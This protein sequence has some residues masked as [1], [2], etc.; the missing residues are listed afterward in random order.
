MKHHLLSAC[1]LL[2]AS[3]IAPAQAISPPHGDIARDA[4]GLEATA[5]GW[6]GVGPD[7]RVALDREAVRFQP[8][9]GRQ[10]ARTHGLELRL[11][12]V[13]RGKKLLEA[14]DA[15]QRRHDMAVHYHRSRD[16]TERWQLRPEGVELSYEFHRPPTGTGDLVVQ[17]AVETELQLSDG[18]PSGALFSSDHGGVRIGGVTGIDA[19]GREIAGE[20]RATERTLELVL[21]AAFVDHCAYP[22][23]LDPLIGTHSSITPSGEDHGVPEVAYD[24]TN[25]QYLVVWQQEF[26]ASDVAIR[27]RLINGNGTA[28]GGVLMIQDGSLVSQRPTV[29]NVNSSNRFLVAWQEGPSLLGP[30]DLIG[31]CVDAGTGAISARATLAG[32]AASE[33]S[34]VAAGEATAVDDEAMLVWQ[35][36]SGDIEYA[37]VTCAAGSGPP[38]A[39]VSASFLAAA[40]PIDLAISRSG[41]TSGIYLVAWTA[42]DGVW[43]GT[44]DRDGNIASNNRRIESLPATRLAV[45]GDGASFLVAWDEPEALSSAS[46]VLARKVIYRG[47]TFGLQIGPLVFPGVTLG[48]DERDPAVSYLGAKYALA[49]SQQT[50]GLLDYDLQVRLLDSTTCEPCSNSLTL[51]VANAFDGVPAIGSQWSASRDGSTAPRDGDQALLAFSSTGVTPPFAGGVRTQL[52]EALSGGAVVDLQDGCGNPGNNVFN[53]PFALG[54]QDFEFQLEDAGS[55]VSVAALILGWPDNLIDCGPCKRLRPAAGY[56]LAPVVGGNASIP[57]PLPCGLLPLVGV[58]IETQWWTIGS[59]ASPCSSF[60]TV[61]FSNRVQVTIDF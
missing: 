52:L 48:V 16:L 34:P 20:L 57:S 35:L 30:F 38:V 55:T 8:A 49:W 1:C 26:S 41:G 4:C 13:R 54:N 9:L 39:G 33:H 60:P 44:L 51:D 19:R 53:G 18:S 11:V 31:R 10:A 14:A 23:V 3:S 15:T 24:A 2:A 50:A 7:Y 40:S 47:P 32:S 37:Q 61:S 5:S 25:D 43:T 46:N 58:T 59:T 6:R 27:G 17:L 22:M 45:D 28:A 36:A 42:V 56:V 21:P 12:S 29:A